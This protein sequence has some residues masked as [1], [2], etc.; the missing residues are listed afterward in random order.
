MDEIYSSSITLFDVLLALSITFLPVVV[1]PVKIILSAPRCE[2]NNRPRLSSPFKAWMTPCGKNCW[3]SSIS[4][5]QYSENTIISKAVDLPA[6]DDCVEV[7]RRRGSREIHH[8]RE[9]IPT[10]TP[11]L[12]PVMSP[13]FK[14]LIRN[15][16]QE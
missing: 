9:N 6:E 4:R 14:P 11:N 8:S 2:V 15:N 12:F 3:A 10:K 1:E 5:P 16:C 13:V 7:Q